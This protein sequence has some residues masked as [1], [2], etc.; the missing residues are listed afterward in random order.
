MILSLLIA[1][2]ALRAEDWTRALKDGAKRGSLHGAAQVVRGDSGK[3]NDDARLQHAPPLS[4]KPAKMT[5]DAWTDQLL[6][7]KVETTDKDDNWLFFRTAQLDDNDRTWVERIE[8][9]GNMITVS[10]SQARWQGR[11]FRNFTK[12]EV[13]GVNLGK[14]EAGKYEAKWVVRPLTFSKFDGD[15]K[16]LDANWPKDEGPV[17][18]KPAELRLTF[19]V[20]K[21]GG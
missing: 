4:V 16:A 2:T 11:Y 20:G 12:Y 18:K 7:G 19:T 9:R 1:S 6:K 14:L 8:R 5:L 13:V 10:V 17:E 15:G 3:W 21:G